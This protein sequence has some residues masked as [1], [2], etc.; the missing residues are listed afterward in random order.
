MLTRAIRAHDQIFPHEQIA[1]E[2]PG[3]HVEP[4]VITQAA[5][6]LHENQRRHPARVDAGEA[7]DGIGA[8]A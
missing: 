1:D 3:R 5:E 4:A 7:A 2:C 6:Q 8:E